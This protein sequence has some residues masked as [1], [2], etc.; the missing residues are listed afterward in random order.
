MSNITTIFDEFGGPGK[1]AEALGVKPSAA[2]EM[3]RRGS[4]PVRYWPDLV[5]ACQQKGI[6]I[7]YERLVAIHTETTA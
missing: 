5:A 1:M 6:D 3:K 4:I 2:S 7:S